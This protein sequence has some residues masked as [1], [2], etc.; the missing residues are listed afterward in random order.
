MLQTLG[1]E[2]G[3]AYKEDMWIN[4]LIM[5]A[6]TWTAPVVVSDIR[7]KNELEAIKRNDGKLIRVVRPETDAAAQD[8]GLKN[9]ASES[10]QLSF[11]DDQFDFIL[12]NTGTLEELYK[13]VDRI[14]E[15]LVQKVI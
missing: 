11:F 8:V 15:K 7:F 12:E 2:W 1:T 13:K 9:H 5:R 4:C 6:S 14:A 10:E 3:R